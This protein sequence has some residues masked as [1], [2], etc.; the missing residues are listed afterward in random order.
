MIGSW[1]SWTDEW[2]LNVLVS[3]ETWHEWCHWSLG[4]SKLFPVFS[5]LER[6][7]NSLSLPQT[8]FVAPSLCGQGQS[9]ILCIL[10]DLFYKWSLLLG[11]FLP[12][13]YH[14]FVKQTFLRKKIKNIWSVW[15]HFWDREQII[16]R[17]FFKL[18]FNCE[19]ATNILIVKI[20]NSIAGENFTKSFDHVIYLVRN[21][22]ISQKCI[23]NWQEPYDHNHK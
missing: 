4:A 11:L 7:G 16:S 1:Y 8:F 9:S 18:I 15:S 19:K 3:L 22:Q 13:S 2:M 12:Y 17:L 20:L 14:I 23:F 10:L 21:H 6:L 5:S